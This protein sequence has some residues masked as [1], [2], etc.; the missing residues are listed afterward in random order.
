ML[1]IKGSA[2]SWYMYSR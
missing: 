1:T 2:T